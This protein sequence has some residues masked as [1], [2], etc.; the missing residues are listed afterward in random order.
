MIGAGILNMILDYILIV[1]CGLGVSGAALATG[2]GQC[3]PAIFGLCFFLFS[4]GDLHFCRFSLNIREILTAC[5]NGSSEMVSQLSNAIITF[6]FN[7][8]L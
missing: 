5:Y 3:V 6:L 7:I 1:P 4:K 2:I 8:V